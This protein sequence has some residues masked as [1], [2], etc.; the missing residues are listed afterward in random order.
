MGTPS[1][2]ISSTFEDLEKYRAAV[3][4]ALEKAGFPVGRMEGYAASDER[5][6]NVCLQ[7]VESRDIYIGIFAWR[8]GYIPPKEHGNVAGLSITECEYRHALAKH[9]PTLCFFHNPKAAGQWPD[10]FKDDVTGQG[11]AGARIRALR[12]EVGTEKMGNFFGSPY[13]LAAKVLAAVVSCGTVRRPFSVPPVPEGFIPRP[14]IT[15]QVVAALLAEKNASLAIYGAGGFGKTVLA[16]ALC[17]QPEVIKAFPDGIVWVTLGETNPEVE[18][19]L[20]EM[21]EAL[22]GD[23]PATTTVVGIAANVRENLSGKRCLIVADDVWS[24]AALAPFT[25]LGALRLIFTTRK[26]ELAVDYAQIEIKEMTAEE[27]FQLLVRGMPEAASHQKAVEDFAR[28]LC[29]WTLLLKLANARLRVARERFSD[30]KAAFDHVVGVYLHL[31]VTGFDPGDAKERSEA[32]MKCLEGGLAAFEKTLPALRVQAGELTLFPEDVPIP[33]QALC[34][35]WGLDEFVVKEKVL[36]PLDDLSIVTWDPQEQT[37]RLHNLVRAALRTWVPDGRAGHRRLLDAW[38]DPLQ[39]PHEY[40]WRWYGRHCVEATDPDRL[41]K[42]LLSLAWLKAKLERT[43]AGALVADC[44]RLVS[45]QQITWRGLEIVG[46]KAARS[47]G[48]DPTIRLL[49]DA[50]RSSAHVLARAP[51]Q[52]CDQLFGRLRQGMS[53]ELDKL[54]NQLLRDPDR[55]KLR[56]RF[57]NLEPAGSPRLR[58]LAGHENSVLGALLLPDAK[59]ALS[60]SFDRTLRLWDLEMGNQIGE[61]LTGHEWSV[62]GALLLPDGKRALSWSGDTTIRLWDLETRKQVGDPFLGHETAVDGVLL[63][64]TGKRAL[65]WSLDN[66]LRLWDLETGKQIGE[67]LTGHKDRVNGALLLPD[68]KRALSWSDDTTMRVWDLETGQQVGKPLIGH[69]SCVIGSLLLPCGTLALSWSL[70]KTLRLW[71]LETGRQT[72]EP[73]ARHEDFVNGALL[74]PDGKRALYWSDDGALRL[75][76]LEGQQ[77]IGAS[78]TGLHIDGA[79][80]L[81]DGNRVLLWFSDGT[82]R[83]WDLKNW[84]QLGAPLRSHTDGVYG[85]LLLPD[86]KRVL[87]WSRDGTLRL[88]DLE[89]EHQSSWPIVGHE[90]A[91]Y[92]AMLLKDRKAVLSWSGDGTLRL[93]ELETGQELGTPLKHEASVLGAL[94]LPGEKQVLSWSEDRTLRLWDTEKSQQVGVPLMQENAVENSVDGALLLPDGKRVLSWSH[95]NTLRLWDVEKGRQVG[96][97]LTGHNDSVFGVLVLPEGKRALSWSED[98]TLRLWDLE[99]GKQLGEPLTGHKDWVTGALLL[100]GGKR[101][102]SRSVD[103]TLRLWQLDTGQQIGPALIGHRDAVN[104]A[105]LLP[106]GKRA[107]SWSRDGTLRLWNLEAGHQVGPALTGHKDAIHGALLLPDGKRA[108]SWSDDRTLR[109]W[110]LETGLQAGSALT[111]HDDGVTGAVLLDK[112]QAL[113]WSDDWTLRLWDLS[114]SSELARFYAEGRIERLIDCGTNRFF[115]GDGSGRVYFLELVE[116]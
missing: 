9:K 10:R 80:S 74:L 15:R 113:S 62:Y 71:D 108:L 32:V 60:W 100:A 28:R 61:P 96:A 44:E 55:Q 43:E 16:T 106:D 88:W 111:G 36:R 46:L 109:L 70:D 105:L 93:W 89:T 91:I 115:A 63:L 99:T 97:A 59:R 68:G 90:F 56:A 11:D 98:G 86:G 2:Y 47:G 101:A 92:G 58:T 31:G 79:S 104:G 34:E 49:G 64:P 69:E 84:R 25:G 50:L 83:V 66:T 3:F 67:P 33:E 23:K 112:N 12:D 81:S 77:L 45:Q 35:L 42:L 87:S 41:R 103:G 6:L 17:H 54:C 53:P 95:D 51:S 76:D 39:L 102:L 29:G 27:S 72:G 1:V 19:K 82:L 116:S 65:S 5:P 85:A 20:A 78:T 18:R 38:S 40:A 26:R 22:T 110:D 114:T 30:F 24:Y 13:E 21:Y 14:E 8:Y 7:D 57:A 4:E 75:S 48:A 107:L 94:L 73:L 52:L 37:V